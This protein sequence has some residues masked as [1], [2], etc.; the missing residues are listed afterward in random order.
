[1]DAGRGGDVGEGDREAGVDAQDTLELLAVAE[2]GQ[3]T[4]VVPLLVARL[5]HGR[6]RWGRPDAVG[7]KRSSS[8]YGF[9]R[10]LTAP[11]DAV[12]SPPAHS[13]ARPDAGRG[14]TAARAH[15]HRVSPL[16]PARSR[17]LT[18]SRRCTLSGQQFMD[19]MAAAEV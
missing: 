7:H 5:G 4:R 14:R 3:V 12:N 17:Q 19:R 9:W 2:T 16:D 10:T 13:R 8:R 1:E 18:V 11:A 15:R 6:G